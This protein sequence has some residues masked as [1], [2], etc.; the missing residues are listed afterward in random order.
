[1]LSDTAASMSAAVRLEI[2]IASKRLYL[3]DLAKCRIRSR[4]AA[5]VVVI[6]N[7]NDVMP[8]LAYGLK[9]ALSLKPFYSGQLKEATEVARAISGSMPC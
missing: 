9:P 2:L 1:M 3:C 4:W 6:A 7:G 8:N 5:T